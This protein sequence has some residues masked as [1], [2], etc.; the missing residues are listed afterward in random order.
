MGVALTKRD[1]ITIKSNI[2]PITWLTR[3]QVDLSFLLK[4]LE[5][6]I[7]NIII[8][9]TLLFLKNSGYET[10]VAKPPI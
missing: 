8:A 6:G 3:T 1:E 2:S 4:C 9:L 7:N 5:V 10:M